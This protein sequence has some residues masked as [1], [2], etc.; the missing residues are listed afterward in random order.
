[1]KFKRFLKKNSNK[2]KNQN[3]NLSSNLF[4]QEQ[5]QNVDGSY[6]YLYETGNGIFAEE[7]GFLKNAGTEEEAQV[8]ISDRFEMIIWFTVIQIDR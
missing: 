6:K 4:R 1:M 7:E 2:I 5:E 8:S 3:I